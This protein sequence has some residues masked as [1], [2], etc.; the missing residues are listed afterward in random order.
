[1]ISG[2]QT[3]EFGKWIAVEINDEGVKNEILTNGLVL[4]NCTRTFQQHKRRDTI[5]VFVNQLPL[6]ITQDEVR[7][8]FGKYGHIARLWPVKKYYHETPISNGDWC[9]LFD[10]L[11]EPIPS[12]VNVRGWTAYVTYHGQ[13]KTCRICHNRD[14]IARDCPTRNNSKGQDQPEN[15]DVHDQPPRNEENPEK[16]GETT[17][18]DRVFKNAT[19]ED[20]QILTS[21]E[22]GQDHDG[23]ERKTRSQA[24]ADSP[25]ENPFE[26]D[27]K[28]PQDDLSSEPATPRSI[29][30]Q[31]FGMDTEISD[32][33]PAISQSIW[34]DNIRETSPKP[35]DKKLVLFC[36]RCKVNSHSEEECTASVIKEANKKALSTGAGKKGKKN[37]V[38]FRKFE[39]DLELV[40]MR[41]KNTDGVQYI[42][43]MGDRKEAYA[44]YLLIIFGDY[45]RADRNELRMSGNR[46]VMDLWRRYS[47]SMD[48]TAA[49]DHLHTIHSHL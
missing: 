49:E 12:Y 20:C 23:Q 9:L 30:K 19:I 27:S 46:E 40:V 1:M 42:L 11:K 10:V 8:T 35:E 3:L 41:G 17:P 15:M 44:L 31:I 47:K 39:S 29:Q 34:G 24:W 13:A 18:A 37:S 14:H 16:P 22:P 2:I 43:E 48:K 45:T 38:T 26:V 6:G 7:T 4:K 32:D 33:E 36:P 21:A 5:K 28:K 25:E